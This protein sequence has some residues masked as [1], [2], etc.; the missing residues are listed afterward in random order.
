MTIGNP[1]FCLTLY[2]TGVHFRGNL[3]HVGPVGGQKIKCGPI[4][5]QEIG[6][7]RLQEELYVLYLIPAML[8]RQL[9]FGVWS[10]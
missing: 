8:L 10:I 9:N 1:T 5:T 7:V 6:G 3:L 2:L 4:R